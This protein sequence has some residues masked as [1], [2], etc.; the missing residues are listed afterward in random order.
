L[1]YVYESYVHYWLAMVEVEEIETTGKGSGMRVARLRKCK[2][3]I[4]TAATL[5]NIPPE[6]TNDPTI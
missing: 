3:E 2:V 5:R 1:S 4:D 6:I